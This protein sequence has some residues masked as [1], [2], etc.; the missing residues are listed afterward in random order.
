VLLAGVFWGAA[1]G[2]EA[3]KAKAAPPK[4]AP[5]RA[6]TYNIHAFDPVAPAEQGQERIARV[7]KAGQLMRRYAMELALH[8]P[9]IIALQE[10]SPRKQVEQ[11]ARD[12][13]MNVAF[14]R[15]GW[16]NKGWPDGIAGAVLSRFRIVESTDRP[17]VAPYAKSGDIFSRHLGRV[18]LD[19]PGGR[20]AVYTA[21]LLPSYPKTTHIRLGEIQAVAAAARA[22]RKRGHSVLVMGDM[23]HAPHTPEYR[24]WIDAGFTDAFAA[25]GRGMPLTC[26]TKRLGKRIDYVFALG[27]LAERLKE[28]RVLYEGAFRCHLADPASWSLS[29]H[30]PV[31][32]V[33]E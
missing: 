26:S 5:I 21:H 3:A 19:T 14:F 10:A 32:A 20:I 13:K 12:L 1:S 22:D 18:L 27:P 28:C 2:G 16:K 30:V 33:F 11:L 24:A 23:N 9:D 17:G 31:L 29:D 6:I 25:R 7:R 8:R 4:P 15:G